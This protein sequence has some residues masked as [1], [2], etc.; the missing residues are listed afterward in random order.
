MS[1]WLPEWT[2]G[3]DEPSPPTARA[4]LVQ[5]WLASYGPGTVQDV[6]W[7]TGWTMA[8]TRRALADIG[9]IE[10]DLEGTTGYVLPGD[11]GPV[12]MPPPFAVLLP[13]LDT[14]V[15]GWQERD[16]FL[17]PHG[18][19]L[20]DRSGN[21]G[22]TVWWDGRVVGG[23]HQR[24]DGDVAYRLLEDVGADA[25]TAIDVAAARL[26]SWLGPTRITPRF[27]TPL[28]HELSG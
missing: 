2:P 12:R 14:S 6:K 23:W 26:E 24:K 21:G 10:V 11:E 7:W 28:E 3:K 25:V 27:R 5:R 18:A 8:E 20:F 15:M 22:P 4:Q 17:G 16:W 13:G 1:A 9:A 19:S